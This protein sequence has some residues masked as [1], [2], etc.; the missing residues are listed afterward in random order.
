MKNLKYKVI[1]IFNPDPDSRD[2]L[3]ELLTPEFY[4]HHLQKFRDFHQYHPRAERTLF[5]A[6]RKAEPEIEDIEHAG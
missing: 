4:I 6:R 2:R 5:A 1:F 3:P